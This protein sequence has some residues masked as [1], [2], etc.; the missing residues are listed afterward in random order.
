SSTPASTSAARTVP[1]G[2]GPRGREPSCDCLV[3]AARNYSGRR[4]QPEPIVDIVHL[5]LTPSQGDRPMPTISVQPPQPEQE[6]RVRARDWFASGVRRL[7][8]SDR[9]LLV[10]E[11]VVAPRPVSADTR[12]L[13]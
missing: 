11:K 4:P 12:W 3:I 9:H 2:R 8:D 7:Y 13:T 10:F 6:Q 1:R 5:F